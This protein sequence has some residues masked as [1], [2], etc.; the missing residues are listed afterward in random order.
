MKLYSLVKEDYDQ[1]KSALSRLNQRSVDCFIFLLTS[2]FYNKHVE[3]I[4]TNNNKSFVSVQKNPFYVKPRVAVHFFGVK[5]YAGEVS[6][7][8]YDVTGPG[9][10]GV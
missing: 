8:T 3:N 5:H 1:I 9:A 4:K 2:W 7:V 6:P 10:A